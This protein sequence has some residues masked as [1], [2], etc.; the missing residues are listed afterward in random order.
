MIKNDLIRSFWDDV[1]QQNAQNL[2]QYFTEDAVIKW[3]N[4]NE[5]FAVEEWIV[6]NCEYPGDWIGAV[7]RIVE[8]GNLLITVTKVMQKEENTAFH[9]TSFF[10][11]EK[12][13]IAELN[14]YWSEDG[15]PPKWRLEKKI[16]CPIIPSKP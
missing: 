10:T 1:V 14:E 16:G 6:A 13:K 5:L 4:T 7:E 9:T 12:D 2:K 15:Q 8:A 11:F 3:H